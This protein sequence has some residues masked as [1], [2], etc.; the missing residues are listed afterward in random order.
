MQA[1]SIFLAMVLRALGPDLGN[2]YDSDDD[3]VPTRLPLLRNQSQHATYPI[4][5][6]LSQQGGSWNIKIHDKVN[7]LPIFRV[8]LEF[9]S[10]NQFKESL[11]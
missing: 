3:L 9:L 4:D 8:V 1:V 7:I 6:N 2:Y 10:F 5:P 11:Y